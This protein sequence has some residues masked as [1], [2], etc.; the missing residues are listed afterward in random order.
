MSRI[1]SMAM[2]IA[3]AAAI[4][5]IIA[6]LLSGKA[7]TPMLHPAEHAVQQRGAQE[8]PEEPEAQ[9]TGRPSS[10]TPAITAERQDNPGFA[11]DAECADGHYQG[12]RILPESIGVDPGRQ[13]EEHRVRHP[14]GRPHG[15]H[16]P[17]RVRAR[18][19]HSQ[20]RKQDARRQRGAGAQ[21]G[22]CCTP[23]GPRRTA[24]GT[25]AGQTHGN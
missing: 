23:A 5:A 3:A 19:G 8:F 21:E 17:R 25:P 13:Q 22:G 14:G 7:P 12:D 18:E 24:A 20:T 9:E 15:R 4:A 1:T 10:A 11:A 2:A 16:R 6:F